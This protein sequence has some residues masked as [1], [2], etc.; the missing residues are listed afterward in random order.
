MMID[1]RAEPA[2]VDDGVSPGLHDSD[3]LADG[4]VFDDDNDFEAGSGLLQRIDQGGGTH[5]RQL[6]WCQH[7]GQGTAGRDSYRFPTVSALL[8]W[9]LHG[10]QQPLDLTA[11]EGLYIKY[12][13]LGAS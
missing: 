1:T 2:A 13:F 11:G 10:V 4:R 9:R 8:E 5:V 12:L 6:Q 7:A 3:R